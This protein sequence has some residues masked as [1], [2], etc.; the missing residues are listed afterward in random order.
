[1]RFGGALEKAIDN[2]D[3]DAVNAAVASGE[4]VSQTAVNYASTNDEARAL[5]ALLEHVDEVGASASRRGS[6]GH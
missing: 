2:D 4:E 1:M 5:R 3:A 6:V